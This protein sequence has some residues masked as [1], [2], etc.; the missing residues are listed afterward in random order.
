[1]CRLNAQVQ[2]SFQLSIIHSSR[3][4]HIPTRYCGLKDW[5]S[6]LYRSF[7][8]KI[9]E[10]TI[11]MYLNIYLT[12][13]N[14]QSRYGCRTQEKEIMRCFL[15]GRIPGHPG[16]CPVNFTW[17]RN[18]QQWDICWFKQQIYCIDVY[19]EFYL[20]SLFND[21]FRLLPNCFLLLGCVNITD[22]IGWISVLNWEAAQGHCDGEIQLFNP[23]PLQCFT[24]MFKMH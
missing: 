16:L 24:L 19:R 7:A 13:D 1:M 18:I 3:E 15:A 9:R 10:S 20:P 12:H 17:N 22:N 14:D 11:K 2:G 4:N 8:S 21:L 23:F 5:Q 6:E